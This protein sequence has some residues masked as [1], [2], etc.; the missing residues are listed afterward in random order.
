MRRHWLVLVSSLALGLGLACASS[1]SSQTL[2]DSVS[3][4]FKWSS[5]SADSSTG[6]SAYR[7]DVSDYTIAF[8]RQRGDL[9]A[10][11]QGLGR[12]AERQGITNWEA[13]PFT[14]ASIGLGLQRA[15]L[16]PAAV[17]SFGA[18]LFG[19]NLQSQQNLLAGYA[20]IP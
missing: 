2:S 10:L 1:N 11:R 3:S 5:S 8:T 12:L 15:Q 18:D 20:S 6:Q 13:D 7:Q 17:E 19:A 9:E 14:C 4:P 16:D